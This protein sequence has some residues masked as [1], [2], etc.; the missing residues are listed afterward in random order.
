MK[1]VNMTVKPSVRNTKVNMTI[2]KRPAVN[3]R[4]LIVRANK[5]KA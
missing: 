1:K 2:K 4:G 3:P 5:K